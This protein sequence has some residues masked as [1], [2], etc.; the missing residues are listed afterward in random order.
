M[1]RQRT[2]NPQDLWRAIEQAG[3]I[4]AYVDQQLKERG[5]VVER[6]PADKMSK[7]ELKQYKKQLKEEAAEK[8]RIRKE[9]WQAYKANHIV[10]LGEGVFWNDSDDWDKWDLENSE[11]RAAANELPP[12]DSPK[13]LAEALGLSVAEL[14][15]LAYHRDAASRVHY[16]H[17]T[18]KKRDGSERPIWAPMTKLKTVQR[19]ILRE[20]LEKLIIHGAVHGFVPGRSTLTNAAV[21][22][23]SKTILKMDIKQFFPTVTYPRV[24]G[25]FRKAGYRK[26]IATLLALLCTEPPREIVEHKGKSYYIAMG[27]RCLPQGAPTSPAIT[28]TIC[29]RLDHRLSG[30]AK[31]YGWRFTR[32]ADDLT[33]SL[34]EKHQGTPHIGS[35]IGLVTRIV[36]DEGFEIHAKK[37]RVLRSG[38]CQTV[39]GLVVN[40]DGTPRVPRRIRRQV[41]TMVHKLKN[42]QPLREGETH[43][44]LLGYAAYI[45]MTDPELG[46]RLVEDL[47]PQQ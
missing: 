13:Q 8:I 7:R 21:H 44:S 37:T 22:T 1:A 36:A 20:V 24:R 11:E 15:W 6:R 43:E 4:D 16:Y 17:F 39:T 10:H 29:L 40:G 26:Q 12:L 19:W 34:P 38:G 25:L 30:V 31:A 23:G 47:L 41:R 3:S 14:R 5:F 18:I 46:S 33:F 27:P 28:N 2:T 9:A 32:Y 35:M 42:G 45:Y